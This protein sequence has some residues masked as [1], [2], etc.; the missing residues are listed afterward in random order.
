MKRSLSK[1]LFFQRCHLRRPRSS[2]SDSPIQRRVVAYINEP[3]LASRSLSTFP[4][5]SRLTPV[6]QKICPWQPEALGRRRLSGY[7]PQRLVTAGKSQDIASCELRTSRSQCAPQNAR[8]TLHLLRY[9]TV[10]QSDSCW[11][12]SLHRSQSR[13]AYRSSSARHCRGCPHQRRSSSRRESKT[14]RWSHRPRSRNYISWSASSPTTVRSSLR[15]AELAG[16]YLLSWSAHV[17]TSTAAIWY[18]STTELASS[19]KLSQRTLP[20][21]A[22]VRKPALLSSTIDQRSCQHA[23]RREK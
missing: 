17:S 23:C 19:H 10:S 18:L 2:S 21:A 16:T 4:L 6:E 15:S 12:H 11:R 7:L 13:P 20:P 8:S 5:V 1:G 3:L 22:S 14:D 9:A